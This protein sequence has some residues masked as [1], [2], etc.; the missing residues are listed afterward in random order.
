MKINNRWHIIMKA[1]L[2][3]NGSFNNSILIAYVI[4]DYLIIRYRII[5]D[6]IIINTITAYSIIDHVIITLNVNLIT[7]SKIAIFYFNY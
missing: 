6:V 4:M 5:A 2:C 7:D 3:N 1:C